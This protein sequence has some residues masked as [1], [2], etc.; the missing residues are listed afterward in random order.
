MAGLAA[1]RAFG[2]AV[3]LAFAAASSGGAAAGAPG[4]KVITRVG[5]WVIEQLDVSPGKHACLVTQQPTADGFR[6]TFMRFGAGDVRASTGLWIADANDFY[7]MLDGTRYSL[8]GAPPVSGSLVEGGA[9]MRIADAPLLPGR[10]QLLVSYYLKDSPAL[11]GVAQPIQITYDLAKLPLALS[12][13]DRPE[14][15]PGL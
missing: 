9:L 13:F 2:G 3:V 11:K 4:E 8:D 14:C 6:L 1:G 15:Q 7:P 5:P 10:G 12:W